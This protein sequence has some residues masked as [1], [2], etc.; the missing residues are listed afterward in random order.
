[1]LLSLCC[2]PSIGMEILR[3]RYGNSECFKLTYT[4]YQRPTMLDALELMNINT[5]YLVPLMCT[6]VLLVGDRGRRILLWGLTRERKQG[7]SLPTSMSISQRREPLMLRYISYNTNLQ[8]KDCL[9]NLLHYEAI[10]NLLFGYM[11]HW[12]TSCCIIV[13]MLMFQERKHGHVEESLDR[14]IDRIKQ[15]NK[16]FMWSQEVDLML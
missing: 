16:N 15:K 8:H 11:C 14:R 13:I 6:P 12:S 9:F 5:T 3:Y 2:I 4:G 1:M 10:L 7:V